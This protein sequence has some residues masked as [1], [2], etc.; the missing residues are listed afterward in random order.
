MSFLPEV[1]DSST[2]SRVCVLEGGVSPLA[3]LSDGDWTV[4]FL[5]L[6]CLRELVLDSASLRLLIISLASSSLRRINLPLIIC[7]ASFRLREARGLVCLL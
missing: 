6:D 5:L 3:L 7:R 2:F 1:A 4:L